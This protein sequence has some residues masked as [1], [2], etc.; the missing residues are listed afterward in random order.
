MG[1]RT[2]TV[3]AKDGSFQTRYNHLSEIN[4]AF[5]EEV[6]KNQVIGKIGASAWGKEKGSDSHLHYAIKK[7]NEQGKMDWYNPMEG[8][9]NKVENWIDPQSWIK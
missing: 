1:G 5:N 3:E 7:K 4:V 9:E 8:K 2:I 6:T